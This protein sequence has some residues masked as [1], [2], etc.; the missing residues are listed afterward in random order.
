MSFA[1]LSAELGWYES[2]AFLFLLRVWFWGVGAGG[3]GL[4]LLALGAP[5]S[6]CPG[7]V[8]GATT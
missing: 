5:A 2:C 1:L 3:L 8:D 6:L 7:V 4:A